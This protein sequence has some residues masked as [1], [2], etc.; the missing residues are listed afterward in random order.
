M[1]ETYVKRTGPDEGRISSVELDCW[2]TGLSPSVGSEDQHGSREIEGRGEE[3]EKNGTRAHKGE[4]EKEKRRKR[5]EGE[6][7]TYC[8]NPR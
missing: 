7:L 2:E 5:G 8:I 3:E 6:W 4:E 1:A